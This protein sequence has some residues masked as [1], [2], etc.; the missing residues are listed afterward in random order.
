MK[1]SMM[2]AYVK[3][4][5]EAV[6]TYVEAFGATLGFNVKN[7]DGSY[8]HAEIDICG[9]VLAVSEANGD[10]EN[11]VTGGVMQFCFQFGEGK[12]A[13]LRRAYDVLAQDGEILFPLGPCDYSPLAADIV[14]RFGARWCLFI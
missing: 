2:Q 1:R 11:G 7:E 3:N 6:A 8:Y 14:D 4:S 12:E 13:A 10:A 9:S 5:R